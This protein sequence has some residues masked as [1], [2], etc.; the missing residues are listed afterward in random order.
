MEQEAVR[1]AGLY[2]ELLPLCQANPEGAAQLAGAAAADGSDVAE[3]AAWVAI[4]R[5]VLNLDEFVT[6]E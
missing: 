5:T 6:R 3:A 2:A 4:A 1:L